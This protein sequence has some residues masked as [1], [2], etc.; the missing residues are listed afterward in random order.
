M[1]ENRINVAQISGKQNS[2][3]MTG[4]L[5]AGALV[6]NDYRITTEPIEGGHRL[7]VKRGSEVQ[8]M[9]LLDG[10]PGAAG[11]QGEPGPVGPQGEPGEPGP[12]GVPGPVGPQGEKGEKGDKGDTGPAGPQGKPGKDAPQEA[13][14][15]T[16]QTLT[17][18]QQVQARENVGAAS[19][20][21]VEAVAD[22]LPGKLSEPAEGLAVGKYFRVAAID[23]NGHAVMEAVDAPKE[24]LA[25]T[26]NEWPEWTADEQAAARE[27]M[28]IPGGYELIA[29]VT[30]EEDIS[31]IKFSKEP[32]GTPFNLKKFIVMISGFPEGSW[33]GSYLRID[34]WT[35]ESANL[36]LKYLRESTMQDKY[37]FLAYEAISPNLYRVDAG[38]QPVDANIFLKGNS[39]ISSRNYGKSLINDTNIIIIN[40][41]RSISTDTLPAGTNIK[42]YGVRA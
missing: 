15:Y 34:A 23:E 25:I 6:V 3:G 32:D 22:A 7:T 33:N 26:P 13:V 19:A 14:L 20:E 36:V 16:P 38:V 1:S 42:L 24:G 35:K 31:E 12:Q 4:E 2:A 11:P 18:E 28:G 30:L 10:A 37:V 5:G 9:N 39:D 40:V 8:T 41:S 21:R 27:R 17:T 29:D